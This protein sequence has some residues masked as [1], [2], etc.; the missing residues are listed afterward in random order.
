MELSTAHVTES[1]SAL[2]IA[3]GAGL[4]IGIERERRKGEGP[5]QAA[6]GVRTFALTSV[7]GAMAALIGNDVLLA[8]AGLG[9]V[10]FAGL[11]YWHSGDHDPGLTTEVALLATFVVGALSASQP[12]LAGACGVLIAGLLLLRSHLHGFAQRTLSEQ[13]LRDAILLAAAAMIVLPLL[14]DRFIDPWGAINP[15]VVWRLTVVVMLVNAVGYVAQRALG[16]RYGLP[17]S[18]MLGGFVS[19]TAV[20]AA[21]GRRAKEDESAR[22]GAIAAA[23]LS[24]IATFVQLALVLAL[25]DPTTLREL[26]PALATAAVVASLFGLVYMRAAL[27]QPATAEALTGRA[28]SLVTALLFAFTFVALSFVAVLLRKLLGAEGVVLGAAA[29]GFLDAHSSSAAVANL[30]GQ[31]A[32]EAPAAAVAIALVVTANTVSKLLFSRVGGTAFFMRVGASLVAILAAFWIAVWLSGG[33][34]PL[35]D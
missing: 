13:E 35:A 9:V 3:L 28:F 30:V 1:A 16:A 17:L 34:F 18:G 6:A 33:R 27:R 11:S 20:H 12:L 31:G 23:T 10:T 14:P 24:N 21:M 29:G 22:H 25:V 2:A 7:L 19:S 8:I 15:R 26:T 4:L 5:T 32:L